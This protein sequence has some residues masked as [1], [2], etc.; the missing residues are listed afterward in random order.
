MKK[1]LK[2]LLTLFVIFT[3]VKIIIAYFI[4]SSRAFSDDYRYLEMAQSF[5]YNLNFNVHGLPNIAY[6]PLY[7]IFISPAYL[8]TDFY[9][10][11]KIINV[12]L[13]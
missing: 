10:A 13:S 7:S 3:L 2:K 8:F 1:E 12:I 6:Q 5:F 4:P 11:I 9:L